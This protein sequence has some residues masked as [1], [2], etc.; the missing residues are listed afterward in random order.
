LDLENIPEAQSQIRRLQA[1]KATAEAQL[2]KVERPVGLEDVIDRVRHLVE[3][4]G[5]LDAATLRGLLQKT[6][7][8]IDLRFGV[9]PKKVVTRYPLLG[10][11]VHL[12]GCADLVRS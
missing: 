1:E 11:T 6:V 4:A 7:A 8:G 9:V 5:Q 3:T 12:R 2:G 10:V